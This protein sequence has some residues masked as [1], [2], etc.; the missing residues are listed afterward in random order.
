LG[1]FSEIVENNSN[2]L[3]QSDN[4]RSDAEGAKMVKVSE[5]ETEGD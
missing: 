3:N 4:E 1:L 2:E 5:L